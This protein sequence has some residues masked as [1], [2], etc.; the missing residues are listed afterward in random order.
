MYLTH[1]CHI[2]LSSHSEVMESNNSVME[3][4]FKQDDKAS[5]DKLRPYENADTSSK[6][7]TA[8]E[9]VDE[10]TSAG[11]LNVEAG[12]SSD[13]IE[14]T[15]GLEEQVRKSKPQ[16]ADLQ[17]ESRP[18]QT[19]VTVEQEMHE[20]ENGHVR[21][22]ERHSLLPGSPEQASVH[23]VSTG[24]SL[25]VTPSPKRSAIDPATRGAF[26]VQ[27]D[28][29]KFEEIASDDS[30]AESITDISNDEKNWQT[31]PAM[32]NAR[33]RFGSAVVGGKVY[34]FGGSNSSG[35]LFTA[36]VYDP[37]LKSWS[38]LPRMS[39]AHSGS[40][41]AAIGDNI[42]IIGGS[43]GSNKYS[44]SVEIYNVVTGTYRQGVPL[45]SG[46][47]RF[48]S[49]SIGRKIYV[50]GGMNSHITD[51]TVVF[52]EA[53]Q[54]WSDLAPM[55]SKRIGFSAL[56]Y[57]GKIYA[58]GGMT[59]GNKRDYSR[60]LNSM[61]VYDVKKNEWEASKEMK[62]R[63]YGG[64]SFLFG[65]K[66]TVI[67]G[68][69]DK[70][71]VQAVE[72]F[73][74]KE[75]RWKQSLLPSSGSE[76]KEFASFMEGSKLIIVGGNNNIELGR[77]SSSIDSVECFDNAAELIACTGVLDI[78]VPEENQSSNL[79]ARKNKMINRPRRNRRMLDLIKM[80]DDTQSTVPTR[81]RPKA[82]TKQSS[83]GS[84][85]TQKSSLKKKGEKRA[86]ETAETRARP[87]KK[88]RQSSKISQMSKKPP[89]TKVAKKGTG[90]KKQA[91]QSSNQKPH[92]KGTKQS[93]KTSKRTQ[94]S[95]MKKGKV[96]NKPAGSP[97]SPLLGNEMI[98]MKKRMEAVKKATVDMEEEWFGSAKD[99]P[100]CN[101]I[102]E[103][104]A[105][106]S[107]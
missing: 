57:D 2:L 73:D 1:G 68:C 106:F 18:N 9:S 31:L 21:Q 5:E 96:D 79:E 88:A 38:L 34:I 87:K 3:S 83:N 45:E 61:E 90:H 42:Y 14:P 84:K 72:T 35:Q 13:I 99:G 47:A 19:P 67:G 86:Q 10:V 28:A 77:R 16:I 75:N 70:D 11:G 40:S 41:C 94:K 92:S 37:T 29:V 52:D 101:R 43:H 32:I 103:L 100:L 23:S 59:V 44:V 20:E 36:E 26:E 24:R 82:H 80:E 71:F 63:R 49:V 107:S 74:I 105:R 48:C 89:M 98:E 30:V 56:S 4:S 39:S 15:N 95:P 81:L 78:N 33:G 85:K 8:E 69:D 22:A 46:R 66:I 54:V 64:S 6:Y 51:K 76:R 55:K 25:I 17:G 65:S 50:F 93:S 7:P 60:F 62:N 27:Q 91:R 53:T 58:M 12:P 97:A 104:K 102:D